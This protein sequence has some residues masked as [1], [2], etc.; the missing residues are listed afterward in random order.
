M[1]TCGFAVCQG[2]VAL[3]EAQKC[4]ECEIYKAE[5]NPQAEQA[6]ASCLSEL[7]SSLAVYVADAQ[8][9][10]GRP[11]RLVIDSRGK[12]YITSGYDSISVISED[13]DDLIS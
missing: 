10:Y 4:E 5:Q 13:I 3:L 6:T 2:D 1:K 11:I 7:L 8:E 12:N 9:K